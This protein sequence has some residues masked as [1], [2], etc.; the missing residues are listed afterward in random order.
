MVNEAKVIAVVIFNV[1]SLM[2]QAGKGVMLLIS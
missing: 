2:R 1:T